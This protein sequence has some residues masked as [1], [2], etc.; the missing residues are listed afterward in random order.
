VSDRS[1]LARDPEKRL[2]AVASHLGLVR[3]HDIVEVVQ[4]LRPVRESRAETLF[5]SPRRVQPLESSQGVAGGL[6]PAAVGGGIA[7]VDVSKL[8]VLFP[9]NR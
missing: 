2:I 7:S 1:N 6:A 9:A 8:S 3:V 4:T 5:V